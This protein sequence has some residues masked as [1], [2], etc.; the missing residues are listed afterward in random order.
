MVAGADALGV[1]M[2]VCSP[3]LVV[4]LWMSR[5]KPA[6]FVLDV[7]SVCFLMLGLSTLNAMGWV[8]PSRPEA[9]RVALVIWTWQ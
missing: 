7:P 8:I 2:D 6:L 4:A 3:P 1:Q 5:T 9:P